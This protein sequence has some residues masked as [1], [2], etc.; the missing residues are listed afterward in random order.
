MS[1][2]ARKNATCA[3]TTMT[4]CTLPTTLHVIFFSFC[5]CKNYRKRWADSADEE[6]VAYSIA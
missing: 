4:A 2:Q 6:A 5:L 1:L 3:V